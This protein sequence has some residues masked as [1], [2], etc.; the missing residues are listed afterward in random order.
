L[1]NCLI[2]VT[3]KPDKRQIY[4]LY[5][6]IGWRWF[7]SKNNRKFGIKWGC[8]NE[9]YIICQKDNLTIYILPVGQDI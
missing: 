8:I 3:F 7:S 4:G 9:A 2:D 5:Q 6:K 1:H